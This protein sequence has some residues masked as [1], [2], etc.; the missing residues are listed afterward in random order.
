[1][2]STVLGA[3]MPEGSTCRAAAAPHTGATHMCSQ[4][5]CSLLLWL[6]VLPLVAISLPWAAG[7]A[8]S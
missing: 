7:T 8:L 6:T 4:G 2:L 5:V 1:M 3:A